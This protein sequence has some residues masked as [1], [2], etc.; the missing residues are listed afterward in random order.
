MVWNLVK[1]NSFKYKKKKTNKKVYSTDVHDQHVA[2]ESNLRQ[3]EIESN[4]RKYRLLAEAIPQIVFTFSPGAGLTYTNGK[5]SS[6]SGKSFNQTRGLGFMSCVHPEDRSKLQLPDFPPFLDKA[7]ISWQSEVRLLSAEDEYKWFLVKCV[8]VDELDTG[9]VR[10]FGTC[11]DI[12]DHK[13]LEKKLKEAHDAAQKSTESKTRFLS[14]MSHEIRTPLI[15]ITG[16]L[17][18]LLDTELTAEQMDYVHTIQQSAESLLVVINDIL[19]LSKVEAGMMKLAWE[20]FSLVAMIEDA[21]ELLSTLAIQKDLELSFWVDDDVPDVV[22]GDRVR[23][24]QVLLNLIGVS[25]L[26]FFLTC[27]Y[28]SFQTYNPPLFL[29]M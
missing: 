11:T 22:V 26:F 2:K 9:E 18:F 16:M 5:W 3:M 23:L 8:S 25:F 21:N 10:W 6:Y 29:N 27:K 13:L 24:R 4:E 14:N 19:D 1:T 7:G 15:G 17:N 12:N 28:F 20:P